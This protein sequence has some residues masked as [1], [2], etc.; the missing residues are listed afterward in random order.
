MIEAN[1]LSKQFE[2]TMID[3]KDKK[4]SK[5][6]TFYA[7]DHEIGRASFRERVSSPV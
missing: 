7:V 3:K 2:R 1:N 5:K 4:K 6:E